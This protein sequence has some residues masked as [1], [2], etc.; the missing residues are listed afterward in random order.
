VIFKQK[1]P[2]SRDSSDIAL[3]DLTTRRSWAEL[4]SRVT[5]IAHLLSDDLGL[6][7]D[8]HVALLMNNRTEFVEIVLGALLAGV[9]ITPVNRHLAADEIAYVIDDSQA[10]VVFTDQKRAAIARTAAASASN[11]P[12]VIETG[13]ELETAIA[14]ASDA[15]TS[16]RDRFRTRNRDRRR[17]RRAD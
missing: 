15:T 2:D 10:R 17:L 5:R 16:H 4:E 12:T 9:W 6:E 13:S 3:D 7:T 1:D 8:D 14:A 11:S